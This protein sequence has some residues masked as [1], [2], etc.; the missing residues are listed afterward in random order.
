MRVFQYATESYVIAEEYDLTDD[1]ANDLWKSHL[2]D[3]IKQK[4]SGNRPEMCIWE[5]AS[6]GAKMKYIHADECE[7]I[8]GRL[9]SLVEVT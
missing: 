8:N 4:E 3:F 5:S 1:E 7:V 6:F 2:S 9:Y